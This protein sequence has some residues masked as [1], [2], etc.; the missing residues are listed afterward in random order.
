MRDRTFLSSNFVLVYMNSTGMHQQEISHFLAKIKTSFF[1]ICSYLRENH[2]GRED[3][4]DCV[5]KNVIDIGDQGIQT[6][7]PR[8][9]LI[10]YEIV[11]KVKLVYQH[12][13]SF[14]DR[15]FKLNYLK[16]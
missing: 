5:T 13:E 3:E 1:K 2:C 6:C 9:L 16:H 7:I 4:S 12:F 15:G 14:L 11:L 10:K 8:F